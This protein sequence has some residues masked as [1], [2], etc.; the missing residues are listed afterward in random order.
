LV[1][2]HASG[3]LVYSTDVGRTCPQCRQSISACSCRQ[4]QVPV[5][6]D[7]TV[8]VSLSTKARS[9]KSVTVV[10]GVPFGSLE[11]GLLGKQLRSLCGAGGTTKD[12]VI[13]VQGDHCTKLI[14]ELE[15]LKFSVKRVGG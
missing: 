15:K 7:G 3:G 9:G 12:G 4:R 2:P 8:R 5:K 1:K 11:L 14:A 10:K 6:S 13:E